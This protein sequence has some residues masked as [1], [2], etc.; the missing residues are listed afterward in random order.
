MLVSLSV[1]GLFVRLGEIER[2]VLGADH[3]RQLR[4][5]LVG[6]RLQVSLAL[7]DTEETSRG[8]S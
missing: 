5:D 2:A 1:V 7:H 3:R 6:E 8:W 4:H